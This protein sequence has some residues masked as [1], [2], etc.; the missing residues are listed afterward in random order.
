MIRRQTAT[1]P[2]DN[3]GNKLRVFI[4]ILAA[5][6]LLLSGNVSGQ[7]R[8]A[9]ATS[10]STSIGNSAPQLAWRYVADETGYFSDV[11]LADGV[12]YVGFVQR[13]VGKDGLVKNPLR[14]GKGG[15]LAA[16]DPKTGR[17]EWC[18]Y[19][20]WEPNPPVLSG[21]TLFY[22]SDD[23][24]CDERNN[25]GILYAVDAST[26]KEI[27]SLPAEAGGASNLATDGK[28]LFLSV[29]AGLI[30]AIDTSSGH[31]VWSF[32]VGDKDNHR[33]PSGTGAQGEVVWYRMMD[34][35]EA[36]HLYE[37]NKSDSKGTLAVDAA[38]FC[39]VAGAT[40]YT[41]KGGRLC[42]RSIG[43]RSE[44]WNYQLAEGQAHLGTRFQIGVSGSR[45]VFRSSDRDAP[46][47][48]MD[49]IDDATGSRSWHL[50]NPRVWIGD[51]SVKGDTALVFTGTDSIEPD[52][53]V[54]LWA[55]DLTNGKLRWKRK[56]GVQA[57]D[58][59][60][61]IVGNTLIYLDCGAKNSAH[62]LDLATGKEKW[63]LDCGNT[64][65][66]SPVCFGGMFYMVK[67]GKYLA[68]YRLPS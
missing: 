60:P 66:N 64:L 59:A 36:Y 25:D 11:T 41:I 4:L 47:Q 14:D 1:P 10:N 57:A 18:H 27:W 24:F 5:V 2:R 49:C 65:I 51:M 15:Y 40:G 46:G 8:K 34:D 43:S 16:V 62:C 33:T 61:I 9:T 29:E 63:R 35:N 26:G 7:P 12:L 31:P 22:Y 32:T 50:R 38:V 3:G 13:A 28:S 23:H 21:K 58:N 17:R 52:D 30:C 42:A 48:S 53:S 37:V 67:A 68:A 39:F 19:S 20:K 44:R 56:V 54:E 6:I 55:V 45:V